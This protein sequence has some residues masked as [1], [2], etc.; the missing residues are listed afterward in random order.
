MSG[1]QIIKTIQMHIYYEMNQLM[2]PY[3]DILINILLQ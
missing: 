2:E 3:D 1:N